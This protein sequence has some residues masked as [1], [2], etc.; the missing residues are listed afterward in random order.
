MVVGWG[1]G[2]SLFRIRGPTGC[3]GHLPFPHDL[4]LHHCLALAGVHSPTLPPAENHPLPS[5]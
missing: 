1:R 5:P 2:C 4:L 3:L